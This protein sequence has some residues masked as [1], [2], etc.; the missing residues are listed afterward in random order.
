MRDSDNTPVVSIIAPVYNAERFL[1]KCLDSLV[2][3]TLESIEII[4]V[5]DGSTD[6]STALL[7]EWAGRDARMRVANRGN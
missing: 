1:S 3:Q 2:R 6:S 7:A 5:G 4:A